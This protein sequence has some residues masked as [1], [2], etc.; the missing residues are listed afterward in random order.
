MYEV[1]HVRSDQLPLEINLQIT[2]FIRLVWGGDTKGDDRFWQMS[3]PEGVVEHYYIA[4]RGVLI[5]HEL[6]RRLTITHM[7][8]SYAVLGVGGVFT[9][10]AFRKEGYGAQV[11]AAFSDDIRASNAD[12]GL[13][14]TS[15]RHYSF[16]AAHGWIPLN[17]R[18]VFAGN[19]NQPEFRDS[20]VML[21]PV[22]EKVQ[23]H[24]N[25][26]E[27]TAMYVGADTW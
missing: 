3:D 25:D 16:Y 11:V 20:G 7:G 27:Q 24:L 6:V 22:S 10:P 21:L 15:E 4:E 2:S 23:T 9:Y 14:F 5:S 19:P 18:G 1:Q 26:F 12:L 8:E 13:L 17:R